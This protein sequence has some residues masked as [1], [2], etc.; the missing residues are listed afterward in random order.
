MSSD[1]SARA[2]EIADLEAQER[3]LVLPSF[4]R[5]DAWRLG[6][7]LVQR[8][9]TDGLGV[10]VDIRRPGHVLFHASLTGSTPDHDEW[11]RRKTALVF[12]LEASS[13]LLSRRFADSGVDPFDPRT[14]WL[15]PQVYV[16]AG[17][18]VPIRVQGAGVVAAVTM[19]GLTSEEDH[20]LVVEALRG[21]LRDGAGSR[22]IR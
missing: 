11:I 13:L 10:A 6:S 15:D 21:H 9:M 20:A 3:E 12:R 14:G 8:A 18:C 22:S 19:S 1:P 7:R 2:A 16:L 4:D 5:D 17:G